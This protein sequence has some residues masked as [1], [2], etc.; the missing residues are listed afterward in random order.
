MGNCFTTKLG[1]HPSYLDQ[2]SY[3][4]GHTDPYQTRSTLQVKVRMTRKEF[5]DLMAEA[6]LM[7]KGNA[8]IGRLIMEECFKGK[9]DVRLVS[10][11]EGNRENCPRNQMNLEA[12]A[13]E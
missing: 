9:T 8:E 5:K 1:E 12:I 6:N 10:I 2:L 13:E 7:S 4:Y 11:G 3:A